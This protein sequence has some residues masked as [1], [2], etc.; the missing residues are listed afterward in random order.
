MHNPETFH[1]EDSD[2]RVM[3][4]ER[5]YDVVRKTL[6]FYKNPQSVEYL[7]RQCLAVV[8]LF[9]GKSYFEFGAGLGYPFY[10]I[11]HHEG[12]IPE[13]FKRFQK[14][15]L[16][17]I[18]QEA[19]IHKVGWLCPKCRAIN[20]MSDMKSI[21]KDCELATLKPRDI[22]RLLPDLDILLVVSKADAETEIDIESTLINSGYNQSDKDI[23]FSIQ[24]SEKALENVLQNRESNTPFPIDVHLCSKEDFTLGLHAMAEGDYDY[25]L[26][27]KSLWSEWTSSD[28][29]FFFDFAFSFWRLGQVSPEL[30][31]S[32]AECRHQIKERF[33]L[34][35]LIAKLKNASPR[36]DR[37]LQSSVIVEGLRKRYL[38]W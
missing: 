12:E 29:P 25:V 11:K 3:S 34:E 26:P 9:A 28:I 31:S 1:S 15:I 22:F 10:L 7:N 16:G 24:T 14:E 2:R 5:L 35:E 17:K 20:E 32:I 36:A 30:K 6:E 38:N 4:Y 21:C 27:C 23:E 8:N 18:A 33:S 19:V 37:L 13:E